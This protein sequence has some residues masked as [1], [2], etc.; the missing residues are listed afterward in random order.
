LTDCSVVLEENP[1][2]ITKQCHYSLKQLTTKEIYSALVFDKKEIPTGQV[3][4][5]NMINENTNVQN[6][7]WP[8]AYFMINKTTIYTKLREFQ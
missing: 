7:D 4:L 8:I 3:A 1:P 2:L 5:Q 6:V